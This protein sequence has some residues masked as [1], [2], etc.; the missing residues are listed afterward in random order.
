MALVLLAVAGS[1]PLRAQFAGQYTAPGVPSALRYSPSKADFQNKLQGSPWK[2]GALHLSPWIGLRDASVVNLL[3]S[4]GETGEEDFTLTVGAGLRGYLPAGSK[5]LL[6]AHALPE[7]VWWS[8]NEAKRGVHGRFGMGLFFFFNRMDI[9]ISHRRFERQGFF[10]SEIQALTTSGD[11][12]STFSLDLEITP[13]LSMFGVATLRDHENLEEEV[14]AFGDLDRTEDVGIVGLRYKGSRGWTFELSH[15]DRSS[16]FAATARD[17]SN[18]GT[19]EVVMIALDRPEIGFRLNVAA[20]D[21]E[22]EAGSEFGS[23]DDPTGSFDLLWEAHRRF[24]LLGY[25]RRE[26][27]YS[28]DDRYA[29]IVADRQGARFNF[30]LEHAALGV[31]AE[32][33]DDDY[34]PAS[35]GVPERRDDVTAY[36]AE[37]QIELKQVSFRVQA[38]RTEYDSPLDGFDR[39]VTRISMAIDLAAITRFTSTLVER[40][41]LGNA[42]SDW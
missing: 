7:Y 8:D 11:D 14:D 22:A 15:V 16:D 36:G 37:L 3:N 24:A 31:F 5:F 21:R 40:L 32:V 27:T 17:L 23:F 41:S 26:Q 33:G 4:Q 6:A 13:K 9:E 19:S 10:S 29:L 25:L 35:I 39:D 42:E 1:P 2:A 34:T 30:D 12:V 20:N 18:S 38:T 28:V